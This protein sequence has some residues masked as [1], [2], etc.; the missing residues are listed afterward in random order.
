MKDDGFL[1]NEESQ[2]TRNK[3][4]TDQV[5]R[6]LQEAEAGD[7]TVTQICREKGITKNTF[8]NW[9]A[10]FGGM[11]VAESRR[12]KELERENA[13]VK[14]LLAERD[15]EVAVLK[16]LASNNLSGRPPGTREAHPA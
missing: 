1:Q 14:N 3:F 4:T 7:K 13:R 8:Y 12:L 16:E 10:K 11:D 2:M 6:I 5:V 15:L 9:K